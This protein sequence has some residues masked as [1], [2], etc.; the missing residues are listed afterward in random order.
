MLQPRHD[1]R[2]TTEPALRF[3]VVQQLGAHD[4]ECHQPFEAK[5]TRTVHRAH[6]SAPEQ[7]LD[8]VLV[9]D[10]ARHGGDDRH[11]GAV[12]RTDGHCCSFAA[13]AAGTFRH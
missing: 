1:L 2:F 11:G 8:A 13:P 5:V 6:P 10:D 12:S 9:V 4:F 7:L 3:R